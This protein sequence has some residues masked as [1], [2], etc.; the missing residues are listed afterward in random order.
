MT[1]TL[2]LEDKDNLS[3]TDPRLNSGVASTQSSITVC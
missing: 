2:L 3:T 1:V